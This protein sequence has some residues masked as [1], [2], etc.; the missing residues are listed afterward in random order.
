MSKKGREKAVRVG[1]S[2]RTA[3]EI[4]KSA[5]AFALFLIYMIPFL[6]VVINSF[7]RKISIVKTPL[8]LVDDDGPQF[9]NYSNAFVDMD[10]FRAFGNS[11][12][13]V[14]CSVALLIVLSSM[15]AYILV[16]KNYFVCKVSFLLLISYMVVPFQVIMIPLLSIYGSTFNMLNS[17]ITLILMNFGFGTC[18]AVFLCHGFNKTGVPLALEEAAIIDGCGPIQTFFKIV[19]PL[20]KP[21]L[22]T[23][24]ILQVLGLWNDYLLPSLVLVRPKLHTLP[25]A[26]RTFVGTFSSDYGN[27]MAALVMTVVPVIIVYIALQKYIIGGVVAG[28]VKS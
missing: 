15:C 18:F 4:G 13:V 23:I 9:E 25:I 24:A 10:F 5:L 22:S 16:R 8:Q 12:F 6:L 11:L 27:M 17:R 3:A 28:A 2:K 1:G 14:S 21:I 19:F 7:K 20:L 26:I